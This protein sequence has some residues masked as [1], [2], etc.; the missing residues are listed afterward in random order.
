MAELD[1]RLGVTGLRIDNKQQVID[2]INASLK[3]YREVL[4]VECNDDETY[5]LYK[6]IRKQVKDE[7]NL[8][9]DAVKEKCKQFTTDIEAD[10]KELYGMYDEV[11]DAL[12]KG[13]KA[14]EEEYGIGAAKAAVT[15]AANKAAKA[16]ETESLTLTISCPNALA[17]SRIAQFAIDLGATIL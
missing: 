11:Y 6:D 8:I 16:A 13:V 14:Y 4:E 2:D 3:E 10:K 12:D 15:R 5:K 7:R 9:W 1:I 17:K